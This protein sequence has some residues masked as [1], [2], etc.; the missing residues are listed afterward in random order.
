MNGLMS[1]LSALSGLSAF[2][3]SGFNPAVLAN[4]EV[5]Y[6][7]S[8]TTCFQD[9]GGTIPCGD[10]DLIYLNKDSSSNVRNISQATEASRPTLVLDSGKWS[11][12]TDGSDDAIEYVGNLGVASYSGCTFFW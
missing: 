10:T 9:V 12:H 2:I 7:A 3:A 1:G 11:S 6:R 4:L 8:P 5:W